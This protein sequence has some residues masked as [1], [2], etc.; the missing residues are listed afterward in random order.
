MTE[1]FEFTIVLPCL[2]EAETL[3]ICISKAQQSLLSLNISGEILVADNGSTD[4][5]QE[6]AQKLGAR[7]I[8][9]P[10]KGYGSALL[11][12]FNSANS[13]YI[14]MADA[15]DS[16][17]L[18]NLELFVAELRNGNDLVMGNRFGGT[19]HKGAMPWLHKHVG[20]PILSFLGRL[21]FRSK[22]RDFHCGMRGL[23]RE[24]I[25]DLDLHTPGM[26]FASELV[27]KAILSDY[28]IVEVPT[29]LK[30]DGRS[31]APHLK[32]WRDGWRHLRFL[33]SYSP[34]WLFL[35][36]GLFFALVGLSG[37]TLLIKSRR[38]AF[39]VSFD[40]QTLVILVFILLLGT[41]LMWFALLSKASSIS[42]GFM[43]LD[44]KSQR[45]FQA[46]RREGPYLCYLLVIFIG[47]L[48]LFLQLQH[49]IAMSFG[50][51]NASEVVR[52]SLVG[53]TVTFI[54]LQ[55]AMS[56]FLLSVILMGTDLSTPPKEPT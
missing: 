20:N 47:I 51:L 44:K 36:P 9:V 42:K 12:G 5:S 13:K 6:I 14:I 45:I 40:L 48:L 30:P 3:G 10:A 19:I 26:E 43:P 21:F 54:G 49:W 2:D 16:Y 55:A 7:I 11:A 38:Q 25:L 39:G 33:L 53:S 1:E 35:Y 34:R 27:V 31:R 29:D 50:E 22:I 56:H 23:N 41:Q 8:T 18:D 17:A 32:T 37:A 15:D 28:K 24:R 46:A 4:G 52:A